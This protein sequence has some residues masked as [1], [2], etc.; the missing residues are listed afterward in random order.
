MRNI[1][2]KGNDGKG[3][4]GGG[5]SG[6]PRHAVMEKRLCINVPE[7]ASMLGLSRN[8]VYDLVKQGQLPVI[9]FG[10]RKLIPE[11]SLRENAGKGG[12]GMKGH[13]YQR[14]KGSWTVIYDWPV[15]SLTG[16]RRQKSQTLK[17]TKRDAERALRE[18]LS[19]IEQGAYV[20]PSKMTVGEWMIQWLDSYVN[21]NT[22]KRT[23]DSYR[24]AIN[25]HII[26]GLGSIILSELTPLHVQK[27]YSD[28]LTKGRIDKKGGLSPK[29]VLYYH[30]I[31]SKALDYSVKMGVVVRNVASAVDPPR[32]PRIIMN[33]LNSQEVPIFLNTARETPY[34]EFFATLLYTGLRRGE[35]LALRWRN[36]DLKNAY[37]MVVETAHILRNGEYEIKEPKTSHSWRTVTIPPSLVELLEL[38]K[39]DQELLRIQMGVSMNSDDF[40][41]IGLNGRP[42]NP[43]TVTHAFAKVVKKAG[44]KSIRMHDLRHTHATLMLMAG[45]HPKIVSER[46]GHTSISVTLDIYSH[47]LQGLQEAAAEKFDRIFEVDVSENS[48]PNVSKMLANGSNIDGKSGEIRSGAGE[49]RTPDLL[50]ASLLAIVL[51]GYFTFKT[52]LLC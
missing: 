12:D 42:L 29:S 7:A 17:G 3:H 19:S 43:D 45:I 51:T 5:G 32:V 37:L 48:E 30:H 13:I 16:K 6:L 15:D 46:L 28:K 41:F 36:L 18:I 2:N 22:T 8:F 31:L 25:R 52:V 44:L 9:I 33:T 23:Y 26:P 49:A 35:L 11:S 14:T 34:Y 40:V 21:T 27:F 1:S 24:E 10:K 20:K 38:H 39:A 50:T 4:E 47:V